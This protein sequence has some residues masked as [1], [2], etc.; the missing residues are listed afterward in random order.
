MV[1]ILFT[2]Q[3]RI[4]K[5][6]VA[7][8]TQRFTV[9]RKSGLFVEGVTETLSRKIGKRLITY[10]VAP[11]IGNRFAHT[12][13][14]RATFEKGR[15]RSNIRSMHTKY[16]QIATP[17]VWNHPIYIKFRH[18]F[19][20]NAEAGRICRMPANVLCLFMCSSIYFF[21]YRI[22]HGLKRVHFI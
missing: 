11:N 3:Q 15:R 4:P 22:A 9:S 13:R 12:G 5:Q 17:R 19:A 14:V 10:S 8:V 18:Y 16:D 20:Q 1:R 21:I 6:A 7:V 2:I